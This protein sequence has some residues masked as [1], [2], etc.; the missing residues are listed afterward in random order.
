MRRRKNDW[1]VTNAGYGPLP[2]SGRG[3]RLW[4][5][6]LKPALLA[7]LRPA[8]PQ[9]KCVPPGI[10]AA[11]IDHSHNNRRPAPRATQPARRADLTIPLLLPQRIEINDEPVLDITLEHAF[12]CFV[13]LL[14]RNHLDI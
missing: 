9:R 8:G 2:P 1:L 3:T 6:G 13:N 12:I 14:H 5:G 11:R 4:T 10:G 7:C